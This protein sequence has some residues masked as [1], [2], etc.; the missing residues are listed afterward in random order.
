L[1]TALLVLTIAVVSYR[2]TVRTNVRSAISEIPPLV[3]GKYTLTPTADGVRW[4]PSRARRF[5]D[6][7]SPRTSLQIVVYEHDGDQRRPADAEEFGQEFELHEQDE[8]EVQQTLEGLLGVEY[9]LDEAYIEGVYL[10]GS[11]INVSCH[12]NR[13]DQ[14]QN[15]T[16]A[17]LR[18]YGGASDDQDSRAESE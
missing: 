11:G 5:G 3:L 13:P 7:W 9:N 1:A 16:K 2:Y 15:V 12:T 14:L 18:Y 10:H 17:I 6:W 4:R 8:N